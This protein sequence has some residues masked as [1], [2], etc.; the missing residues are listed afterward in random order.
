MTVQQLQ[1]T[2]RSL[3]ELCFNNLVLALYVV[4]FE[5]PSARHNRRRWSGERKS[6]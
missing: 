1:Q 5:E 2:P 3:E 6:L 4:G